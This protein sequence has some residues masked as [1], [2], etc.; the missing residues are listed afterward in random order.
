MNTEQLLIDL[1]TI[2]TVTFCGIIEG[3]NR[4]G[5]GLTVNSES[6]ATLDSFDSIINTHVSLYYP[7]TID[8]IMSE[9][10]IKSV[11]E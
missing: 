7:N 6:Q 10:S 2:G 3:T 11:F 4:Y 8:R 9:G 1:S 5:V